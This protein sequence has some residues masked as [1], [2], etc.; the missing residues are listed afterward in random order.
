MVM[1]AKI[2]SPK[3]LLKMVVTLMVIPMVV[4]PPIPKITHMFLANL[5]AAGG[6]VCNDKLN[7]I[8]PQLV[9]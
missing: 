6:S 2:R 8:L 7:Q 3:F 1:V 5:T 9:L 4:V